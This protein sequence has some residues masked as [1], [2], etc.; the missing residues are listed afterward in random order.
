ML[1]WK[2]V[3]LSTCSTHSQ[4]HPDAGGLAFEKN[5]G[6]VH[7]R[8]R[9]WSFEKYLDSQL[10]RLLVP[11]GAAAGPVRLFTTV[12]ACGFAINSSPRALVPLAEQWRS[13]WPQRCLHFSA[14]RTSHTHT[15]PPYVHA[16][17]HWRDP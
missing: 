7:A 4:T 6:S 12:K 8:H 2:Y 16:W 17:K 10:G 9:V 13:A 5:R 15:H 14:E 11:W 3:G 1:E